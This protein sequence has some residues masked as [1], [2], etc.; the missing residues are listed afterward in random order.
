MRVIGG[1]LRGRRL[2]TPPGRSAAVRPTGDRAREAVFSIIG[3]LLDG[4][5]VLDLFCGTG[6]LAIEAL[7]RG[8]AG[9]SLV[10]TDPRLARR[11]VIELGLRA[12]ASVV[13]ADAV[14]FLRACEGRFDLIFCDPPYRLAARLGPA[15][16][17]HLPPRLARFGRLVVE[18]S[19]RSPLELELPRKVSA[20]AER[21]IGEALIRIYARQ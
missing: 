11:N 16:S 21:R 18:S 6:A 14:R 9:A 5:R 12:R 15:L 20:V 8:A 1:E 7:S 10:D 4:A 17:Q 2:A 13:R 3:E 19:A